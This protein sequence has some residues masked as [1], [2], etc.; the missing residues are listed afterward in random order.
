MKKQKKIFKALKKFK[1]YYALVLLLA[2]PTSNKHI[3][4]KDTKI[5]FPN[6]FIKRRRFHQN[7]TNFLYLSQVK[8]VFL[9]IKNY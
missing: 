7:I 3:L 2:F 4:C 9:T 6:I 5:T 8:N 1:L